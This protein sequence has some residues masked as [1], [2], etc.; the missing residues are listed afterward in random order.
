MAKPKKHIKTC[1]CKLCTE[2][3]YQEITPESDIDKVI[4]YIDSKIALVTSLWRG[5]H[6][7]FRKYDELISNLKTIKECLDASR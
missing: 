6:I 1:R 7:P 4:E 2:A 3:L 5:H